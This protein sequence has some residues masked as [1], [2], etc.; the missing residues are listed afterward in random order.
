MRY[1]AS[2]KLEI[3]Q[4]VEESPCRCG[5]R[6][7]RS[8]FRTPPSIAG[9]IFTDRWT[10]SLGRPMS[11][12]RSRLEPH[13]RRRS[14][15]HRQLALDEP[16]LSPRQLAVHFTD[17]ESYFVSEASVYRLLKA[18]DLI[19]S[20]AFI[21]MKAAD[22]FKDKTTAPN[23]LWQTDFTYLK[24]IGWGWFYLSTVLDDFSRY[25]IA[26]KLCT[27]MKADDVT[28]TLEMALDA[29]G[30]D[31]ATVLQRPRLLSDN[32]SSYI[33]E[34]LAKWL[35]RH[36]MAHVRGAPY[37]PMTQGKI[38]R[39]HQTLKNRILLENY[40]LPGDL[41]AQIEA[42]VADYN[43][44]RYHESISNL[45]PADVYFGRGQTIL[46]QRERIKRQTIAQRRLQHQRQAA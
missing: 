10:G 18:H 41:E 45:T 5:G 6:W 39:W 2:E 26:W 11:Q 29:S 35:E 22:Q 40:Y 34:D 20:P 38:E 30:L 17:T 7:K 16:A 43:H 8:A 13:S 23:Q 28:A 9:T 3:I 1:P 31:K 25:I 32:G 4:L 33:S 24:V 19:A 44:R 12:A 46:L 27:T 15:A 36:D 14:R 37:H 21:V 42:F